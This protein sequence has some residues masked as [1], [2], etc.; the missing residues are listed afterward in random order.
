MDDK[1]KV[2]PLGPFP[3]VS[4]PVFSVSAILIVGFIIF[5]AVF[6]ETAGALFT[7]AQAAIANYFGWFLIIV[8]N[9]AVVVSLY[10]AIGPYGRVRLGRQTDK[11][12]YGLFSWTAML[13]SAGI[14]IGLLYWGVAEPLYHYFAPPMAEPETIEAA[15]QAMTISFLHWGIH[16]WAL[17]CIVGLSLAYF[18]YRKGLPLSIRS[19]LYPIIGE[20]IYGTWGH[21]VD[22]LAVFGTMFGIVTT[23][24]LG[25]MQ[26]SSGLN[27]LF[28]IPDTMPVQIILI[29]IITMFATI[30]VMVGLDGG[31]KRISNLN[32][33]L[34]FVL[35]GFVLIFGPTLFVLDSFVE[36]VGNY[37][38]NLV[39][40]SFWS[41]AYTDS[42]WQAGW[43]IFYWAWWVSW[44]P[45]VGIFIARISRGRTVREF[46]LGVLF[47]P[48]VI[49][50]FWFTAFG[51]AAIHMEMIGNPGLIE[52]T[53]ASYGSAIFK[54]LEFMPLTK[55]V[56][57]VVI[58]MIV[59]WF[60]TSSDSGSFVIDMLTA[61]GDADPPRIQ[62]LFWATT[63]GVIA[64]V[65]LIAGGLSAL[66]AAAVV[67]GFPFAA[68][69]LV[70]MYG[71]LRGLGR[72]SLVLYRYK[73]W[74][75]T[76]H[77]AEHNLPNAYVDET[78][79]PDVHPGPSITAPRHAE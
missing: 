62:R 54:L 65:L 66:Q 12:E 55:F 76:E 7:A 64:A 53:K 67:A 9:L 11:P 43:T 74:Y 2:G 60:V 27:S 24:G 63:E 52:A 77:E 3:R 35:L 20:R 56:T 22:I 50:F 32:I 6:T 28:G 47:I 39:V 79:L 58:V 45:F 49:L 69:I 8:A 34:S 78:E 1:M 44:S 71:L 73:Q 16:G 41:E 40:I 17:Y 51:G 42:N 59:I 36:N 31:I 70:M 61:G 25:V 5:G 26:I 75:E 15:E 46:T 21:V 48:V 18:H 38:S 19:A 37:I 33:Q 68:V 4:K 13:F 23:L 29:A 30:S 57:T 10:L 14:G 72:D